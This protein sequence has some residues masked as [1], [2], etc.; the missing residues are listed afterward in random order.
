MQLVS[1]VC[2]PFSTKRYMS[3]IFDG[4]YGFPNFIPNDIRRSFPKFNGNRIISARHHVQAFSDLMGDYEI[5]HEDVNMKLCVQTLEGDARDWF[6]FLLGCSIPSWDELLSAFVKQFGERVS[7]SNY[8]DKFF[9]I[10]IRYGELVP[11][12]NIRF[13]KVLK[14]IPKSYKSDDQ[15][16]LVVYLDAF[17]KKTCYL[18]RDKEPRTLH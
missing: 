4:I 15:V 1:D 9:K 10:Q 16:C 3:L 8:F 11:E 17:D 14:E 7:I 5:Y 13:S 6:S 18:L 2:R 12:F